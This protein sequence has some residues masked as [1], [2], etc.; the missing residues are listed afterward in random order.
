MELALL[1]TDMLSEVLKRKSR[2]VVRKAAAYLR[3]HEQFAISSISR[4]EARRGLMERGADKQ[5]T[6]FNVFCA[7]SPKGPSRARR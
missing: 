2:R 6:R 4:Y 3:E 5:L 1:D 7:H